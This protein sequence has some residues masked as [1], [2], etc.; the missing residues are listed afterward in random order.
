MGWVVDCEYVVEPEEGH[1]TVAN[2]GRHF[3]HF[4]DR[5]SAL[6]SAAADAARVRRLGHRARV[7]VRRADGRLRAVPT[8]VVGLPQAWVRSGGPAPRPG[9]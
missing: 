7:L 4:A 5:R 1:W 6:H 8:Q 3:G 2:Q 9:L